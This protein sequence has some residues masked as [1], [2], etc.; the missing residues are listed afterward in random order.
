MGTASATRLTRIPRQRSMRGLAS[1]TAS[2]AT[3][4]PIVLAL[5]AKPIAAG[6]TWNAC[7]SEGRIACVAKRSTTVR[8]AVKPI[9]K[10][11]SSA[12][13]PRRSAFVAVASVEA[14][15]VTTDC[16]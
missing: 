7:A 2:P 14:V 6:A 5:T 13:A 1:A 11:R 8:N 4:V 9:T 12:S 10:E 3:V 15:V 16:R